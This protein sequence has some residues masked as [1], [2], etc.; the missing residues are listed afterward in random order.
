MLKSRVFGIDSGIEVVFHRGKA[1]TLCRQHPRIQSAASLWEPKIFK[2]CPSAG[3]GWQIPPRSMR[4]SASCRG[5][6]MARPD[7]TGWA[8]VL[9]HLWWYPATTEII[10]QLVAVRRL[11]QREEDHELRR[12]GLRVVSIFSPACRRRT[13]SEQASV[14][15]INWSHLRRIPRRDHAA[16][17]RL[18]YVD[19]IT[20][21]VLARRKEKKRCLAGLER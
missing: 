20:A 15:A 3:M 16:R 4:R 17:S 7:Q 2:T 21:S 9:R 8:I 6:R 5:C 13:P 12:A 18:Q 10:D 1:L 14:R 19:N 11:Y